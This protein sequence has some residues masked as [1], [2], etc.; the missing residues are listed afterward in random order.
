MPVAGYPE[1]RF[2][3]YG[4]GWMIDDY[5]GDVLIH[6]GGNID[7]FSAFMAMVPTKQLGLIVLSN[8]NNTPLPVV[9]SYRINSIV[10]FATSDS[11]TPAMTLEMGSTKPTIITWWND[12]DFLYTDKDSNLC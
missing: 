9:V 7:G 11:E 6:H 2:A 1:V 10:Y 3:N 8:M 5:R 4:L 12:E